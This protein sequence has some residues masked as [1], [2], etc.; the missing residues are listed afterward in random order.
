MNCSYLIHG[1][2]HHSLRLLHI[3]NYSKRKY[4]QFI[5]VSLEEIVKK[6]ILPCE[7]FR[8]FLMVTAM[9]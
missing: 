2:D 5:K 6:H 8:K 7:I 9:H 3:K 1:R 4:N